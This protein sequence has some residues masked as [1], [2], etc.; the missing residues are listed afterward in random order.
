[1][2][3]REISTRIEHVAACR[4]CSWRSELTTQIVEVIQAAYAH[5]ESDGDGSNYSHQIEITPTMVVGRD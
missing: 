4:N 1:M 5:I 3:Y 2:S